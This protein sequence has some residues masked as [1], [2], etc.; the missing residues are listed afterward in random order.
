[1][2]ESQEVAST[3]RDEGQEVASAAAEEGREVALEAA[4]EGREVVDAARQD[5][6]ELTGAAREQLSEISQEV[7]DQGRGLLEE[8][9]TQLEEQANTQVEQLAR[10]LRS[11]GSETQALAEGRT[12]EAGG[13]PGYLENVSGR[14]ERWADD[15]ETRGV[16]GLV[17]DV[18]AFARRRPGVFL[19][20]ATALGFGVGRLIRAKSDDEDGGEVEEV[21]PARRVVRQV[22]TTRRVPVAS[23]A[24]QRGRA[25]VR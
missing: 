24:R 16:D 5:A 22:R 18:K 25:G 20:G 13:L 6:L 14:L 7:V 15:L 17:D 11:F 9:R 12:S 23:G 3:A 4:G 21:V 10:A 19:L 2:D 8:T 1:V